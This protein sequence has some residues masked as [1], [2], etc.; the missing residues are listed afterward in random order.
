MC[1]CIY[2][3]NFKTIFS[4]SIEGHMVYYKAE[5]GSFE[6][7]K[8]KPD[9]LCVVTYFAKVSKMAHTQT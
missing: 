2:I 9:G 5:Y 3:F 1:T 6:V 7:A 8:D 4:F